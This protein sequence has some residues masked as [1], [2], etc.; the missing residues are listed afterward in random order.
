MK[1]PFINLIFNHPVFCFH[2]KVYFFYVSEVHAQLRVRLKNIWKE[3][4]FTSSLRCHRYV[5]PR[6]LIS[7]DVP[8]PL[9]S[10]NIQN[11]QVILYLHSLN[12]F[13]C[14]ELFSLSKDGQSYFSGDCSQLILAMCSFHP[15]LVMFANRLVAFIILLEKIK[16][17]GAHTYH[18]Y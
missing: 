11:I 8:I 7:R 16:R 14:G 4:F 12:L 6:W 13:D 15:H 9:L 1:F 18:Y 2:V 10:V 17:D 5:A 3:S